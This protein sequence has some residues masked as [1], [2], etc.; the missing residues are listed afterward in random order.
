M[1]L[2]PIKPIVLSVRVIPQVS[3]QLA[4]ELKLS[5]RQTSI[6]MITCTSDDAL[7]ASLDEGTKMADVEVVY[8][9]SFYAGSAHAS[10]PFSGEIIG[11]FASHDPDEIA[12]A[13]SATI[14]YLENKAWFYAADE[15]GKLAFF[16]HVIPSVG[17]YLARQADCPVGTPMAYLI[18]PPI[19]AVLGIDAALKAA[20]VTL[21]VF[22][23]PPSET[24]FAG[25]LLVGDVYQCEAAARAFQET[26]IDL[27]K[28]PKLVSP[29]PSVE[30]M[31]ESLGKPRGAAIDDGARFMT[32]SGLELGEKPVEYTHLFDDRSLVPKTHPIIRL[33]GKFDL[34]QAYVLDAQSTAKG[35]GLDGIYAD[36]QEIL[37]FVRRLMG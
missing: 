1:V 17:R 15:K 8:A 11:I 35:E 36:L 22:Y 9:K 10:G 32:L 4:A 23:P 30:K 18:A 2:E 21:K 12:S 37:L 29:L 7:Y 5:G 14:R 28:N 34:L 16:P 27:A 20:D 13:L 3:G 19:E 26:V 31:A 33:R 25:G 6:G 24:N